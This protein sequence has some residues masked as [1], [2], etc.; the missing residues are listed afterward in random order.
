MGQ[1]CATYPDPSCDH[2]P[3]QGQGRV[4]SFD[5]ITSRLA[6][7]N[8]VRTSKAKG[9]Q[10]TQT[11]RNVL[12]GVARCFMCGCLLTRVSKGTGNSQGRPK[13]VCLDWKRGRVANE[14]SPI[15]TI[16]LDKAV[17][18]VLSY[19][20][21][22]LDELPTGDASIDEEV[23]RV[24]RDIV[25][26]QTQIERLLALAAEG[27]ES[28]ALGSK[29]TS[30]EAHQK[31]LAAELADLETLASASSPAEFEEASS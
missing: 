11:F 22:L 15:F 29:I 1:C 14:R 23:F 20:P 5:H 28:E 9:R 2:R 10:K 16:D 24:N 26:I 31:V 21:V 4:F 12:S 7:R 8:R 25:N 17:E 13:L 6:G 18:K 3:V 27:V 30:L 19:L